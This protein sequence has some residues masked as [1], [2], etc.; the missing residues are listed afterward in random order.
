M[1]MAGRLLLISLTLIFLL[2][3]ATA[4]AADNFL[5]R[6]QIVDTANR[7]VSGAEVYVFDSG[8]IKRPADFIS[9]RTV[10][11]GNFRVEL[12]PGKYWALAIMRHSGATFGPLGKEDKHSGEPIEIGTPDKDE[13]R[14]NF[15]I[16]DL[17]EA[18]RANQKRNETMVKVTGHVLDRN[19]TPTAMAYVMAD[20]RQHFGRMPRYLSTWTGT[21]GS[22]TIFLPIGKFFL[23]ATKDFPPHSDY[24]LVKENA[25]EQDTA[26]LDL[27]VNDGDQGQ[28]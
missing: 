2:G 14:H 28:N 6:G 8:S 7:P 12:P 17:Q 5:F 27:T 3:P 9:N 16:M 10:E 4:G 20:S 1:K 11:D 23:G 22:Y 19:G 18:A 26:G 13:I 21:D 15:T 25:F 24:I